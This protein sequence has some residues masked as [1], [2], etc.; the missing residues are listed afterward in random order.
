MPDNYGKDILMSL[1]SAASIARETL[2]KSLLH[3]RLVPGTV[4]GLWYSLLTPKPEASMQLL[5][6]ITQ[7]IAF[8]RGA[9]V[10]TARDVLRRV[11]FL[12][13]AG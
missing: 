2:R 9:Q 11:P 4:N 7:V 8:G 13:A 1:P 12:P 10:H 6:E 3:F 5:K